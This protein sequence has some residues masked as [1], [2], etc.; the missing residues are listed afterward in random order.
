[1]KSPNGDFSGYVSGL[2]NPDGTLQLTRTKEHFT[3]FS[4]NHQK[5]TAL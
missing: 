1:M 5:Y 3:E 4:I 2:P